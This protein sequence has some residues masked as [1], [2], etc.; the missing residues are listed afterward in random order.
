MNVRG[1]AAI[2]GVDS[3][4][5][6]A[7]SHRSNWVATARE[8]LQGRYPGKLDG[9]QGAPITLRMQTAGGS[10]TFSHT[11]P[12]AGCE[13][14]MARELGAWRGSWEACPASNVAAIGKAHKTHGRSLFTTF[15]GAG[16][17]DSRLVPLWDQTR[18]WDPGD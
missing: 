11:S 7:F 13:L 14:R 5:V 18:V 4:A 17:K 10:R 2:P 8:N 16:G 1:Y 15:T 6:M 12:C 3:S 9:S